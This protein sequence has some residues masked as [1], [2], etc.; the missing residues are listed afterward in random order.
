VRWVLAVACVA[1]SSTTTAPASPDATVPFSFTGDY[2]LDATITSALVGSASYA[3]GDTIHVALDFPSYAAAQGSGVAVL[4]TSGPQ[5]G[6]LAI[7]PMCPSDCPDD[8]STE[9]IT[10][11]LSWAS[12]PQLEDFEGMCRDAGSGCGWAD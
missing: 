12:G 6:V 11:T 10:A 5:T 8:P 9:T 2:K 4:V 1:C 3:T 7:T